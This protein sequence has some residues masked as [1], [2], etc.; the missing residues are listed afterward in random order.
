MKVE[1]TDVKY[2]CPQQQIINRAVIILIINYRDAILIFS[3]LS[4]ILIIIE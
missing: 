1:K 3:F 4:K 2:C